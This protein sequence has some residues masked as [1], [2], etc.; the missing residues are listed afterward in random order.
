MD[1]ILSQEFVANLQAELVPLT[2]CERMIVFRERVEGMVA[3]STSLGLEDQIITSVLLA[4]KMAEIKIFTLETGRLF[5]ETYKLLAKM[6]ELSGNMIQLYYP[7]HTDLEAFTSNRG[8]NAFYDTVENRKECCEIR[9]IEPL[10]RALQGARAWI[11]GLRASQSQNRIDM[12]IVAV[13]VER[14]LLKFNPLIDWSSEEVWAHIH[15]QKIPYNVLHDRGFASIGCAP[16]T[17]AIAANEDERAGRWWWEDEV[18]K[19]CGLHVQNGKL[20]RVAG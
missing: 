19:E 20:V 2:L 12:P 6:Q 17:R 5:P 7:N 9:K 15:A 13:D 3:F 11:T 16:C 10:G 14:K 4:E 8:V 18:Q 1:N